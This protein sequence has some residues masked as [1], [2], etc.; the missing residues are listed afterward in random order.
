M[1]N[2]R[3]TS[4]VRGFLAFYAPHKNNL[5]IPIAFFGSCGIMGAGKPDRNFVTI[6]PICTDGPH[7][8]AGTSQLTL[9]RRRIDFYG[10]YNDS[11]GQGS[12]L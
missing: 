8:G 3:C 6:F 7:C 1:N 4:A 10:M 9:F 12:E 5:R 11:C 2:M